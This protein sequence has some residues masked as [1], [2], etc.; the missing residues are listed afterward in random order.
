VAQFATAI[1][2]A[3][4]LGVEFTAEEEV[5]ADS[6]LTRA[7]GLA[8]TAARQTLELVED[9]E[10]TIRG[11]RESTILLP[12]RPV[13]SVASVTRAGTLV[14]ADS[15]YLDGDELVRR[16]GWGG[17]RDTVVIVYTHGF[18]PIP[19]TVKEIVLGAAVRVWVNPGGVMSERLGQVQMTYAMQGTPPGMLLTPDERRALRDLVRRGARSQPVR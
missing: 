14:D 13:V 18:D 12:Q 19:D 8:Q 17:A 4:R 3:D 9:E 15:W 10:L 7:S 2:L 1:E 16:A 5:R 11:S 6:L